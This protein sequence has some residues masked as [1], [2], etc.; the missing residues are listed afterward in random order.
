MEN[1]A[2]TSQMNNAGGRFAF[3]NYVHIID[4]I[5]LVVSAEYTGGR[6]SLYHIFVLY[7]CLDII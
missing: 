6:Q 2:R 1:A 7:K 5:L 4:Y 3:G